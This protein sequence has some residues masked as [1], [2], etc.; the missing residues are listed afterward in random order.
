MSAFYTLL[1]RKTATPAA[2]NAE[3]I[4]DEKSYEQ[5]QTGIEIN[6]NFKF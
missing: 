2:A 5:Y 6:Y 4:S 3:Y 1:G